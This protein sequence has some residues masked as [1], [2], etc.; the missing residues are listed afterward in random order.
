[1]TEVTTC[2]KEAAAQPWR[3]RLF[4]RD[5]TGDFACLA[6]NGL[7]TM[8]AEEL[9]EVEN[10]KGTTARAGP[11]LLDLPPELF[12]L[13]ARHLEL[14]EIGQLRATCRVMVGYSALLAGA[15]KPVTLWLC[16][17]HQST[18]APVTVLAWAVNSEL[19]P[20]LSEGVDAE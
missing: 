4:R 20:L 16:R 2:D 13:I 11:N 7:F 3:L 14:R 9:A 1:M 15:C 5:I 19:P 12:V 6:R 10:L 17:E 18:F 8:A